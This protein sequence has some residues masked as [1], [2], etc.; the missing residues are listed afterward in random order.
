VAVESRT[1]SIEIPLSE[2]ISLAVEHWRLSAWVATASGNTGLARHA[3]RKMADLLS[4]WQ[5]EAV[6]LDGKPFDAGLAAKV[7][8]LMDDPRLPAGTQVVVETVS[9]MVCYKGTVVQTAEIVVAR[10]IGK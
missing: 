9:P 5:I 6:S 10:N 3:L 7:I 4:R 1:S 2:V 8:D